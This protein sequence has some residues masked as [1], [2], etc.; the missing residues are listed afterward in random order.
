MKDSDS[1]NQQ[2]IQEQANRDFLKRETYNDILREEKLEILSN[3]KEVKYMKRKMLEYN[4]EQDE[5]L[6]LIEDQTRITLQNM[7]KANKE[8]AHA[9]MYDTKNATTK[10]TGTTT[11]KHKYFAISYNFYGNFHKSGIEN[12]AKKRAQ[13]ESKLTFLSLFSGLKTTMRPEKT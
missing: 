13:K 7:K 9:Y 11:G 4:R 12:K 3:L 10:I 2:Y 5:Q 1:K 6:E 8:L